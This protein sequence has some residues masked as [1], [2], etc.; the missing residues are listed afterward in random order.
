MCN[1]YCISFVE[2]LVSGEDVEGKDVLELGACDVNGTVRPYL[3]S[4]RPGSYVGVDIMPGSCVDVICDAAH[5]LNRFQ[6][7]SF[8]LVV[9]TEML[10][11]VRDWRRVIHNMKR[12][13]K[14]GGLIVITTRSRGFPLHDH[15]GDFWRYEPDDMRAIFADCDLLK[16]ERD[17]AESGSLW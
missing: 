7:A 1:S 4:L 11:H 13:V 5:L 9:T 3:E 8:D 16:M 2:K 12:V 14:P 10:E 6:P 17:E 15:P